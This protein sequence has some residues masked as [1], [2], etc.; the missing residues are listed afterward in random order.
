MKILIIQDNKSD[1][2]QDSIFLGFKDLYGTDVES[3][4]DSYYLYKGSPFNKHHFWG[5]G[6][7]YTNILN[8]ELSVVDSNPIE[9]IRDNYYDLIVYS[10]VSRNSWMLDEVLRV[11]NG[12]NVFLV[13]IEDEHWRFENL[14]ENVTYFKRELHEKPSSN[15]FP[16]FY[17]IHKS[18]I[19][20]G[21]VVKTKEISQSIPSL[22]YCTNISSSK[23]IFENEYDYYNDY[24]ISK[25]GI[26]QKKGGWDSM[27]HYE[28]LSNKC[29]PLFKDID[30]C[31]ELCL[32]NLPKKLLSDINKNYPNMSDN[33]YNL[34]LGELFEFTKNNLTTDKV[35]KYMLN[36][37]Q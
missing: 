15:V 19:Y 6:F 3:I 21:E 34:F 30:N 18:K 20:E 25:F 1:Y 16:I 37:L 31:P 11:T 35:A 10:S 33:N 17:G 28:I 29:V 12:K 7:T 23:I 13:N 36:F 8:P 27:R 9:K 32:I 5:L 14:S 22:D 26:T 2:L 4:Y 24:R